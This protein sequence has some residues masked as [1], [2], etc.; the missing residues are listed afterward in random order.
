MSQDKIPKDKNI[1]TKK[2][3]WKLNLRTVSPTEL[4]FKLKTIIQKLRTSEMLAKTR[5]KPEKLGKTEYPKL[6]IMMIKRFSFECRKVIGFALCSPRDWLKKL[7]AL[8]HPIR[9]KA[10]TNYDSLARVYRRFAS[11]TCNYCEF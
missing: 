4:N 11:A 1:T 7:A 10:K 9:S 6:R 3:K 8:F 2:K 5:Y